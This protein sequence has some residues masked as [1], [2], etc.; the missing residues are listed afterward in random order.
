[1]TVKS[2]LLVGCLWLWISLFG[3]TM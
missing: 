1:M 2:L 3:W